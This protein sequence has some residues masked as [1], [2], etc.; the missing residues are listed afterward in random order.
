MTWGGETQ[1]LVGRTLEETFALENLTWCQHIERKPLMLRFPGAEKL[2]LAQLAE[3]I[4]KRVKSLSFKKTDF[5][6][7]LLAQNP[8]DWCVPTYI[9]D[10]LVWLQDEILPAVPAPVA[11]L[12]PAP[13]LGAAE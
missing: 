5:A 4:H 3:R 1:N 12:E 7:A 2:S 6:L 13:D 8:N 9:R 10:G 11:G